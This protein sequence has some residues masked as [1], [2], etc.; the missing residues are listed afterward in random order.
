MN[1]RFL[2]I[3]QDTIKEEPWE[4]PEVSA[5]ELISPATARS[6]VKKIR[7]WEEALS[8]QPSIKRMDNGV[9]KEGQILEN[10]KDVKVSNLPTVKGDS[11][12][13]AYPVSAPQEPKEGENFDFYCGKCG[14]GFNTLD[15]LSW[16]QAWHENSNQVPKQ[17]QPAVNTYEIFTEKFSQV[18]QANDMP[19]ALSVFFRENQGAGQIIAIVNCAYPEFL[20]APTPSIPEELK[21][22]KI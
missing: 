19:T 20:S 1:K 22:T 3:D 16:H 2:V 9:W 18:V 13:V 11:Y 17:T 14:K 15:A 5:L 10:E 4:K 6:C 8:K 12:L 7:E 21:N